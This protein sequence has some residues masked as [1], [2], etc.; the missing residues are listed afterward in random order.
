V[1]IATRTLERPTRCAIPG[2][3]ERVST[4]SRS[5]QIAPDKERSLG[6]RPS[7]AACAQLCQDERDGSKG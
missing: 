3:Y 2:R 5:G 6:R 1:R 7:S 4:R